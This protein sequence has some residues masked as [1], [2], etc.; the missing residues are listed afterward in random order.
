MIKFTFRISIL[1][2]ISL[3]IYHIPEK[4]WKLDYFTIKKVNILGDTKISTR[5]LTELGKITY[6]SNIWYDLDFT[7]IENLLQ[8]D[9]RIKKATITSPAIGELSFDIEENEVFCYAQINNKIHLVNDKGEVFGFLGEKE[10]RNVPLII[11]NENNKEKRLLQTNKFIDI[12]K[13]I[14]KTNLKEYISQIYEKDEN[15]IVLILN[16]GT[17][18]NTN[19]VVEKDKYKT[20][21]ALYHVLIKESKIQYIDLRFE[22]FVVK[23]VGDN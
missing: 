1:I 21:E 13:I 19:T 18:I 9:V 20:L 22:D 8:E 4:F 14:N 15:H 2:A 17:N 23:K 5:E 12:I 6:N 3:L 16:D 7:S 11:L 10:K